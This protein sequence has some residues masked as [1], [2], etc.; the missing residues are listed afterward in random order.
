MENLQFLLPIFIFGVLTTFGVGTILIKLWL[1]NHTADQMRREFHE[2][3]NLKMHAVTCLND[4]R[5]KNA[6]KEVL[7]KSIFGDFVSLKVKTAPLTKDHYVICTYD[8]GS[9]VRW[10]LKGTELSQ[11]IMKIAVQPYIDFGNGGKQ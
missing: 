5:K 9:S 4:E 8:D 11:D 6:D 7:L 10:D 2:N 3:S 1:D